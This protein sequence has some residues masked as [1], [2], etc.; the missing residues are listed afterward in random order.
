MTIQLFDLCERYTG[1]N[2]FLIMFSQKKF[3]L[4][5]PTGLR[6]NISTCIDFFI[7]TVDLTMGLK[8]FIYLGLKCQ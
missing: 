3:R 5:A 1:I 8:R 6:K 7:R 2:I 4:K